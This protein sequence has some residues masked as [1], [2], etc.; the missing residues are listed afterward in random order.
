MADYFD[1]YLGPPINLPLPWFRFTFNL[2]SKT[3]DLFLENGIDFKDGIQKNLDFLPI[4]HEED[5]YNENDQT[6]PHG[7]GWCQCLSGK[8]YKVSK[9]GPYCSDGLACTNGIEALCEPGVFP[10][11]ANKSVNCGSTMLHKL[12]ETVDNRDEFYA[13]IKEESI[14]GILRNVLGTL[15]TVFLGRFEDHRNTIKGSLLSKEF[16]GMEF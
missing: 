3:V 7:G 16:I 1:T 10:D 13:V 11:F 8:K 9:N 4:L 15:G 5:H 14:Y 2:D 6:K 12:L